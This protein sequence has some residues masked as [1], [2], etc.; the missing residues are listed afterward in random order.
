MGDEELNNRLLS[1]ETGYDPDADLICIAVGD[2]G[3]G[4]TPQQAAGLFEPWKTEKPDALG[5][6]LYVARSI[7]EQRQGTI[8]VAMSEAGGALF[9]VELPVAEEVRP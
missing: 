8:R 7:L 9:T 3:P 4:I 5:I 6:G 1:I 2:S